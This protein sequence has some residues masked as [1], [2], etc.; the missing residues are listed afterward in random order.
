MKR[1]VNNIGFEMG[2]SSTHLPQ[3]EILGKKVVH[4][5]GKMCPSFR[6]RLGSGLLFLKT[7]CGDFA[8]SKE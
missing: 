3:V 8:K 1:S 5:Y 4:L 2:V 7:R 6:N